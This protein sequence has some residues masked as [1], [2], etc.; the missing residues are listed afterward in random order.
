[1]KKETELNNKDYF[2]GFLLI[3]GLLIFSIAVCKIG[4]TMI[5]SD[6]HCRGKKTDCEKNCLKEF[7]EN[8]FNFCIKKC[9]YSF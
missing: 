5:V 4:F 7:T 3:A 1:M 2:I 6:E 9:D 8:D